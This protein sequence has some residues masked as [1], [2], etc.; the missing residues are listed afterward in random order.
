[1]LVPGCPRY[2]YTD[3]TSPGRC[4]ARSLVLTPPR[5]PTFPRA[6]S[7]MCKMSGAEFAESGYCTVAGRGYSTQV[8]MYTLS[9]TTLTALFNLQRVTNCNNT[10]TAL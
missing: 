7:W 5:P 4:I 10:A 8:A 2:V 3:L 9:L 6:R 1:M